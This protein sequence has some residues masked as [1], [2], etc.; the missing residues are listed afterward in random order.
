MTIQRQTLIGSRDNLIHHLVKFTNSKQC[1]CTRFA[2]S[3][4]CAYHT[5]SVVFFTVPN[6]TS[7]LRSKSLNY[8]RATNR[9]KQN[10]NPNKLGHSNNPI[11]FNNLLPARHN[12]VTHQV[13]GLLKFAKRLL[14]CTCWWLNF[15]SICMILLVTPSC[16]FTA[17]NN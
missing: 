17:V 1:M 13:W 10:Q 4:H 14:I 16:Q 3:F 7:L 12:L 8:H 2:T 15:C 6:S 11:I 5:S 9:K